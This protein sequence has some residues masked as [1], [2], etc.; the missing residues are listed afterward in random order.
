M[1]INIQFTLTVEK[2]SSLQNK[3][4]QAVGGAERNESSSPL[5]Y[6]FKVLK[7]HNI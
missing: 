1:G 4:I 5:Y 7:F 6:K 2:L 3:A